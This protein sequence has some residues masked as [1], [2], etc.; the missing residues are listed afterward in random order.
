MKWLSKIL[1]IVSGILLAII[2]YHLISGWINYDTLGSNCDFN[3]LSEF[4]EKRRNYKW[5]PVWLFFIPDL[6]P[7]RL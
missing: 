7:H 5:D 4:I 3:R 6:Y 1:A 2:S